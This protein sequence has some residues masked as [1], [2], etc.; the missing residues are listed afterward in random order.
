MDVLECLFTV[1]AR[2][3]LMHLCDHFRFVQLEFVSQKLLEERRQLEP[4][5]ERS[6]LNKFSWETVVKYNMQDVHAWMD[7]YDLIWK[8]KYK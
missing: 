4:E 2:A 5:L 6:N 3:Y 1:Q 7:P 8:G